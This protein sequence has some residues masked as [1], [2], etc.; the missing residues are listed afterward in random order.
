MPAKKTNNKYVPYL[1][2]GALLWLLYT[3]RNT[4]LSVT[5]QEIIN[6][7]HPDFRPTA[8]ELCDFAIQHGYTPILTSGYRSFGKQALLRRQDSRN[9]K[10]GRS[11]HNYGLA[12]DANFQKGTTFLRKASSKEAWLASGIPQKAKALGLRWGGDFTGYPDHVHFEKH[13]NPD[14]LIAQATKQFG[15]DPNKVIGNQVLLT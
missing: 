5:N 1:I 12:F 15:S 11:M 3:N 8:E 10:P 7:L 6:G 2:G 13:H 4:L 9:A 14:Q